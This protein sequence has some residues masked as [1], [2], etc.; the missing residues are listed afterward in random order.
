MVGAL[1]R[2]N[3][4][5]DFLHPNTKKDA[6]DALSLFPSRNIYH[7][8]L[9]QAIEIL[10]AV[11]SSLAILQTLV[12][13]PENPISVTRKAGVGIA[14]VEAPRGILYYRLTLDEQG[15]A[16]GVSIIVPTGQN[17]VSIERSIYDFVTGNVWQEKEVLI[18]K[19]ETIVRAYDPCM[20]CASHFLKVKWKRL[21]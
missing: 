20:S 19:I 1:A 4:G 6:A 18:P 5:K 21:S 12:I 13:S 15:K 17:Q 7:N 14:I 16:A 10:H 8:N 9:A 3:L 11:D 2:L